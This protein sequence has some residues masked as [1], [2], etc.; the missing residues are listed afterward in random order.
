MKTKLLASITLFFIAFGVLAQTNLN[1]Y[2]YIIVPNKFDFLRQE[3][4]HRL[5]ELAQFLFNKNGFTALMEGS[6]YPNDLVANRCL[7]LRSSVIKDTGMFKTKLNVVLKDCNDKV[8]YT[9]AVGE[10]REKEFKTAYNKALRAAFDSFEAL[11][12]KYEPKQSPVS[13]QPV[14]VVEEVKAQTQEEIKKLKQE[15][16]TLKKETVKV[17]EQ[18][19]E[20][21]ERPKVVPNENQVVASNTTSNK[22]ASDVLYAQ[23]I[24]NGFQLVDSS[25]K[26]IYKIKTTGV[27]NVFLVQGKSAIV[28]KNDDNWFLE[29]HTPNA[30]IVE[31]LNVKF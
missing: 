11:N 9:S 2:K 14:E 1:N 25:P 29:H 19:A 31:K 16:E 5:N 27:N 13:S 10:S 7:A 28:Y 23:A 20:V 4:Q 18:V 17:E 15:I 24:D 26:V 21:K 8:V 6:D 3:N 30:K 22:S 12:Y